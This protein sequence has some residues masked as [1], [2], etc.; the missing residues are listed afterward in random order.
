MCHDE[1]MT[2][3]LPL[4]LDR[5]HDV[6]QKYE[7]FVAGNVDRGQFVD[8]IPTENRDSAIDL[9]RDAV[10]GGLYAVK[11]A[12]GRTEAIRI[13]ELSLEM[14]L[15][16]YPSEMLPAAE[17]IHNGGD[18]SKIPDMI[19]E[20]MFEVNEQFFPKA[21]PGADLVS[22][23]ETPQS[24]DFCGKPDTPRSSVRNTLR[25]HQKNLEQS[26]SEGH[27]DKPRQPER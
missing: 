17:Y 5:L 18:V 21:P 25:Q 15:C 27:S 22:R 2:A 14:D 7:A 3:L 16:F 23:S 11:E 12:Y 20:G 9:W 24:K 10:F 19:A 26:A 6:V 1:F 4:K 13:V 8:F